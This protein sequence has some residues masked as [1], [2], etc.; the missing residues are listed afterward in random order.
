MIWHLLAEKTASGPLQLRY[1]PSV[2]AVDVPDDDLLL[3]EAL[4]ERRELLFA[5]SSAECRTL[6][7]RSDSVLRCLRYLLRHGVPRPLENGLHLL[8]PLQGDLSLKNPALPGRAV[9][10]VRQRS[11]KKPGAAH[12]VKKR[13]AHKVKKRSALRGAAASRWDILDPLDCWLP[14]ED[15]EALSRME[16]SGFSHLNVSSEHHRIFLARVS[17]KWGPRDLQACV[18]ALHG[19]RQRT[20]RR[21]FDM[22]ELIHLELEIGSPRDVTADVLKI[23]GSPEEIYA[24]ARDLGRDGYRLVNM[25]ERLQMKRKAWRKSAPP[26]KS[27]K[28]AFVTPFPMGGRY[29]RAVILLATGGMTEVPAELNGTIYQ[30]RDGF[31]ADKGKLFE[32]SW[33]RYLQAGRRGRGLGPPPERG[34]KISPRARVVMTTA[35]ISS[36]LAGR[37]SGRSR[38]GAGLQAGRPPHARGRSKVPGK[39]SLRPGGDLDKH[40]RARMGQRHGIRARRRQQTREPPAWPCVHPPSGRPELPD[41]AR[42]RD[43]PPGAGA[44]SRHWRRA[45]GRR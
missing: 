21:S 27:L 10:V 9:K 42:D 26:M 4:Q 2:V 25:P 22:A 1:R 20:S 11:S 6:R 32:W 5:S 17:M 43:G 29:L 38:V 8:H 44:L 34:S 7:Y 31:Y 12:K 16:E 14:G 40:F 23:A 39:S 37:G 15:E 13:S 28:G 45:S 33:P 41:V 36:L 3:L 19:D 18:S 30:G 35:G 24:V